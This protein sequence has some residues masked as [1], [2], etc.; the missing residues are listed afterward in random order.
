MWHEDEIEEESSEL[1]KKRK[2]HSD[3]AIVTTNPMRR[4]MIHFIGI[5]LGKTLKE[6]AGE[7]KLGES[8]AAY[9]LSMLEKAKYI[10]KE[11]DKF[12]LTDRGVGFIS[13]VKTERRE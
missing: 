5:G 4:K 12:R 10:V 13:S 3:L 11:G 7:F 2:E 1:F 9:H 6:I 8:Q